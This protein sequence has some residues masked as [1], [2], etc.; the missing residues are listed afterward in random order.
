[1]SRKTS[2]A[3]SGFCSKSCSC[4]SMLSALCT[5]DVISCPAACKM[6]SD[7]SLYLVMPAELSLQRNS[8]K[9]HE[10]CLAGRCMPVMNCEASSHPGLHPKQLVDPQ[11][12]ISLQHRQSAV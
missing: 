12:L 9:T 5:R 8:C 4:R 3:R 2:S 10:L 11:Q 6:Q 7:V 1:M